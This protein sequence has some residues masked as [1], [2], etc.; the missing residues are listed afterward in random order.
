[1]VDSGLHI[2]DQQESLSGATAFW[3][4][5]FAAWERATQNKL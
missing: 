3:I 1:M 4:I 5:M 2:R